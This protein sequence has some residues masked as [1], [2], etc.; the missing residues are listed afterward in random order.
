MELTA[1][2]KFIFA[3]SSIGAIALSIV[4]F[5]PWRFQANDDVI[6]MWLVSGAY[7]G[8]PEPYAVFIHPVLSWVYSEI[9]TKFPS[10]YWY[11]GL[12]FFI[13]YLS[14]ALLIYRISKTKT[15]HLSR[16]LLVLFILLITIHFGIFPQFT[17]VAG[18]AA[19]SALVILTQK[20]TDWSRGLA[21][22]LLAFGIMIRWEAAGLIL[23]GYFFFSF[24]SEENNWSLGFLRKLAPIVILFTVIIGSKYIFEENSSYSDFLRFN[25]LRAAV[26]DHPIFHE[27]VEQKQVPIGSELFFFSRWYFED[28]G[29]TEDDLRQKK[30]DL[31]AKLWSIQHVLDSFVRLW[32]F[33]RM[34]AFKSFLSCGILGFFFLT[35]KKSHHL[36]LYLGGWMLFFLLFNH[37]YLIH[38]RV[39]ILVFLCLLFPIFRFGMIQLERKLVV[40]ISLFFLMAL[41]FHLH[42][43]LKEAEVR[44]TMDAEFTE[45]KNSLND[46][47][48]LIVEGYSENKW[49]FNF[50]SSNPVPFLSTG[51]ISR[52]EFQKKALKRMN[53]SSFDDIEEYALITPITNTEIVF[54]DYMDHAFG[55]FVQ[56]DSTRSANFI[57][58]QFKKR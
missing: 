12:W 16:N 17:L 47:T 1:R 43:F 42:N 46:S 29:I 56:I 27:E 22:F 13:I 6:M 11:E 31:D 38:G 37:F 48:H 26:I 20:E 10:I 49:G 53:L 24:L 33:Q 4:A 40:T 51:W 54:P 19:F 23:L 2:K 9:Y 35:G 39:N 8:T 21:F 3:W 34:E 45:L 18:L 30:R 14:F 52:S 32:K 55:S 15:F 50:S 28:S 57:L 36:L 41:G 7:T 44:A 5:L 25:R 58:L